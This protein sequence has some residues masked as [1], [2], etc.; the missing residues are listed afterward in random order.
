MGSWLAGQGRRHRQDQDGK[1]VQFAL[2]P[3]EP[4]LLLS[5]DQL[6]PVLLE[7]QSS[8][9]FDLPAALI[10]TLDSENLSDAA[11][12]DGQKAILDP[13]LQAEWTIID[14]TDE[15]AAATETTQA[16]TTTSDS[17]GSSEPEQQSLTESVEL[18][19][20]PL[21]SAPRGPPALTDDLLEP[22]FA[23][24][25]RRWLSITD[26]PRLFSV[27]FRIADLPGAALGLHD[28]DVIYLDATAAGKGWFIDPTPETDTE[29]DGVARV[30]GIDLLSV[31]MH[32]LGHE[33]GLDDHYDTID[34]VMNGVL[35]AGVRR[36]A[37]PPV[38]SEALN[39]SAIPQ[40]LVTDITTVADSGTPLDPDLPSANISQDITIVGADFTMS[41]T[42]TF[43]VSDQNTG[44]VSAQNVSPNW[45]A[46][47][48]MSMRVVVPDTA[49]TAT[50]SVDGFVSPLLQIVPTIVDIDLSSATFSTGS[51]FFILGSG[52][53]EG[54]LTVHFGTVDVVDTSPSSG[55]DVFQSNL[56]AGY[57]KAGNDALS[58][59]VP[60]GA[61]PGPITVSTAGGTSAPMPISLTGITATALEGIPAISGASA[62]PGQ[63]VR[64]SGN[65]FDYTTDVIFPTV[66][67]SGTLSN[68]AVN[69]HFVSPDGTLMEVQTPEDAISGA[70]RVLGA[71][72]T[73]VL[74]VVPTLERVEDIGG[75]QVRLLGGGF[76]K[77][78]LTVTFAVGGAA[79]PATFVVSGT[80]LSNDTLVLTKPAG[81]AGLV[82]VETTGGRSASV[83]IAVDDPAS[84]TTIND[85][86]VFPTGTADAGRLVVADASANLQVIDATTLAFI[87]N[88]TRPGLAGSIIGVTFLGAD[89]LVHDPDGDV[90]VPA[91]SLVV[92][93]GADLPFVD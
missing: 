54:A 37:V 63:S 39:S 7:S 20:V 1:R 46:A 58:V 65:G 41:S 2:E 66:N 34:D 80:F 31:I 67:T 50:V 83:P 60:A 56:G 81:G 69:P 14:E 35:E 33:L 23:E 29:F 89:T 12:V 85:L 62:N 51:S 88:I 42:V 48:G 22:I 90:M 76:T 87:R 9:T 92:A 32:E 93:N 45:V 52:F 53:I 68:V 10:Q 84:L 79:N 55:P 17:A 59:S 47:D 61:S 27:A 44:A 73:V 6:A 16:A 71:G 24:A 75:G 72:P 25:L 5:A 28:D 4:R 18:A 82:Y 19:D 26:D 15:G 30:D 8:E 11:A 91:G 86:A 78:A 38:Q 77:N 13:P 74:Q 70:I 3:M 43:S 36:V 49:T 40:F 64:I 21:D 57:D